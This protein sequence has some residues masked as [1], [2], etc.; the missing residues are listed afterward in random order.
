MNIFNRLREMARNVSVGSRSKPDPMIEV[1]AALAQE[2]PCPQPEPLQSVT[3]PA[4][5]RATFFAVLRGGPL[6]HRDTEQ[7]QGTETLLDALR[8]LRTSWVAYALATTW[9]ET[10][11]TMQPIHE[12]LNYTVNGL[13][14][15]FSRRR[16][17]A[18][19]AQRL[20]RK[21]GE[22]RLSASRQAAIA[23]TIYGGS[24]GRDNLGNTM[25]GDGALFLGRGY[26]QITG[27]TNY[28][29][30][31]DATGY[32]LVGNP[33]LTLRPDIAAEILR[34]GMVDGWFVPG[35]TLE[36]YLPEAIGSREQF[37]AARRIING[38]D[39]ASLIAGYA[40]DFQAALVGGGWK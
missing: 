6:R 1:D 23:N 27:R 36:R 2:P 5:D 24:W 38:T 40:L 21:Q 26:V 31:A 39:K 37:T 32:P 14:A 35:H 25:P 12:N 11:A 15:S 19:D 3:H 17:S 10:G 7:V 22:P 34:S 4:F 30:A 8:G 18:A 20:G 33:D 28:Q 13:L 9:H 29:R 16:I